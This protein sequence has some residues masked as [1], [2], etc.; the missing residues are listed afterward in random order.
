M[1]TLLPIVNSNSPQDVF[2]ERI[3][4]AIRQGKGGIIEIG[5]DDRQ[6]RCIARAA[7]KAELQF[8]AVNP[9]H[10]VP[11]ILFV[12]NHDTTVRMADFIQAV[13]GYI[14]ELREYLPYIIWRKE[15]AGN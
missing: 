13:T 9:A 4:D 2:P 1:T 10:S 12:V 11:N 15:D 3:A 5:T 6:G 7:T 14:E 8:A